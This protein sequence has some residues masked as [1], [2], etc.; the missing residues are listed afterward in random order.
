M[1]EY[2]RSKLNMGKGQANVQAEKKMV[3]EL[4][5]GTEIWTLLMVR[6]FISRAKE[7]D[8]TLTGQKDEV[9][10]LFK[11]QFNYAEDKDFVDH[12]P[13]DWDIVN[14]FI[15]GGGPEPDVDDLHFDCHRV[16]G[17]KGLLSL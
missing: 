14:N 9:C 1:V 12:I 15:Y 13:T 3:T 17:T 7:L 6:C 8:F 11:E 10:D 2:G 4:A 16:H 5:K